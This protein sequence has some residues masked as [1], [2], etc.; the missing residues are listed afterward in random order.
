MS[1]R[2]VRR[3]SL[4]AALSALLSVPSMAQRNPLDPPSALRGPRVRL[5]VL[6]LTG[7]ALSMQSAATPTGVS[8]T[9]ALPP[10]PDFSRGLTQM[11]TT[12]L[13]AN[14]GFVV[15][16]RS[17]I[18]QVLG[19]QDFSVSGRVTPETSITLGKVLGAQMLITGDITEFSYKQSTAGSK[20]GLLGGI[21]K[22]LGAKADRVT[23][24]VA[25]DLRILDATTGEVVGSARGEGKASATAVGADLAVADKS[26]GLGGSVE[27]PLGQASR[28]AIDNAVE[29]LAEALR[30]TSWSGRIGDVR[31]A[32]IYI[33]AGSQLGIAGGMEFEV[34]QQSKPVTDPESGAVL[35]TP[36]NRSGR[37]VITRVAEKYAVA[38]AI[39]GG[40][41]KRNDVV[42]FKGARAEK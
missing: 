36:E 35:G 18:N 25:L 41:F 34:F 17:Q 14:N 38:K 15:L 24:Q 6:D 2:A 20:V 8:T 30:G 22:S 27:T 9:I 26:I 23:A 13:V 16:E 11:L 7:S 12:A 32:E 5:G 40:P 10:P 33:N 4:G 39:E 29:Q 1:Y 3:A 31:G 42:R 21:G 19:E 37:I 28:R